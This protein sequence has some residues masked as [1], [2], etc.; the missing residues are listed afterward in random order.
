MNLAKEAFGSQWSHSSLTEQS[1]NSL[2]GNGFPG[3]KAK[4]VGFW[5][6]MGRD[7]FGVS[8]Q[9]TKHNPNYSKNVFTK[10][11]SVGK[12]HTL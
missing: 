5:S 8:V 3:S 6:N 1:R 9:E 4:D 10:E 2:G 11:C 7:F 12:P